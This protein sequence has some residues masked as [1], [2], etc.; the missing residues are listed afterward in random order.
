MAEA[1]VIVIMIAL[2][3]FA[4]MAHAHIL[5]TIHYVLS[6]MTVLQVIVTTQV[7]SLSVVKTH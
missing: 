2:V 3:E 7:M 4:T 6:M 1:C 5:V